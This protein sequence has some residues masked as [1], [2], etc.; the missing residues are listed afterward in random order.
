MA[1]VIP[2]SC[3][4]KATVGE[5]RVY[6]LLRDTLPDSFTAWYE[7]VVL[8]RRPDFC[9]LAPDFGL[10]IL[11]V[12]G[13]QVGQIVRA[14]DQEI[15]LHKT[16]ENETK[17]EKDQHPRI[18]ARNYTHDLVDLLKSPA[19]AILHL[20]EGAHQGKL[21]FPFGYGIILTQI[22]RTQLDE[23][24]L[25]PIFPPDTT[26]CKDELEAFSA[27]GDRAIIKR[28]RALFTQQFPFDP[29]TEDQLATIRGNLYREVIVK[30][31]PATPAS[32]P[33]PQQLPPEALTLDVLDAQ[34]EVLARSAGS[35]HRIFFGVAGSGKTVVLIARAKMLAMRYPDR[36]VLILCYNKA[37][38]ANLADKIGYEKS[39]Q[40][41]EV[42]NFDSWLSRLVRLN[43]HEQEDWDVFR[44]RMIDR[45]LSSDRLWTDADRYD[46]I[47][48]DEAH[49]FEPEW[50]RCVSSMIR[51][52]PQEQQGDL[53]IALDGAQSLYHANRA[54]T[55]KSVGINAIGRTRRLARNYRNTKQIIEFAW[56]VTQSRIAD[57]KENETNVRVVPAGRVR[58][59]SMPRYRG[60]SNPVEERS[61]VV[62][63]VKSLLKNGFHEKEIAMLYPRSVDGRSG[64]PGRIDA[65]EHSLRA[66]AKVCS[67]QKTLN[68]DQMRSTMKEDGVR[69]MTMH[70]A[71]GLEFKAVI[72]CAIDLMPFPRQTD[73]AVDGRL[74]YVGLTRANE[75]LFVTWGGTSEFTE[76]MPRATKGR[77][78]EDSE[79]VG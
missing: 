54:F 32:L 53:L 66:I 65:L 4:S 19:N 33:K 60:C 22:S 75:E 6:G 28:L 78:L 21:C 37:L 56:Q 63:I 44:K 18:Q 45:L 64:E 51:N 7:P 74:L 10:L 31:R 15:E 11:E 67:I 17:I 59:G 8:N 62:R 36:R 52:P 38:A 69:L 57:E 58:P 27:A 20:S 46:A 68:V 76:R 71:K 70:S 61:L 30:T 48:I 40:N 5:K 24:R 2:D 25:S 29:L 50:F 3:P 39:F 47:L 12:K 16:V 42:R 23:T 79:L 41:I 26:I 77:A 72:T 55:W 73:L 34:Q 35:G 9:P 43:K 49:D 14:T 1:I 13:W